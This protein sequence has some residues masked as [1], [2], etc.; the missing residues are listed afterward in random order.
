VLGIDLSSGVAR[1][2]ACVVSSTRRGCKLHDVQIGCTDTQ[3]AALIHA[4]DVIGIDAPFGWPLAFQ[5]S[6]AS[7]EHIEWTPQIR[8]SLRFRLTDRV[9]TERLGLWPLSVSS[10]RIALPSMRAMALLAREGVTDKSGDGRFF[11]VYP[12]ASLKTWGL[13]CRGY[14]EAVAGRLPRHAICAGLVR[15]HKL[16]ELPATF[17]TSDHSLDALIAACTA[18]AAANGK[19]VSPKAQ[20]RRSAIVEGWIHFPET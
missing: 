19:T 8:D 17:K 7:W 1:T 5:R 11:E 14:K 18:H 15:L 2:A 16:P 12:A 10:D 20:Q 9:V 6:V 4:V 13:P 3:L